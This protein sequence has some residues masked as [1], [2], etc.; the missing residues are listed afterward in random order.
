MEPEANP[1][2]A[3]VL[4]GA[5]ALALLQEVDRLPQELAERVDQHGYAVFGAVGHEGGAVQVTVLLPVHGSDEPT[6]VG[7]ELSPDQWTAIP[8]Y[9]LDTGEPLPS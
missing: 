3:G 2:T 8:K 6:S 5:D 9:D 4:P 1:Q 7:A